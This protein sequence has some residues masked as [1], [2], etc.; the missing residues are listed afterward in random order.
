MFAVLFAS[1]ALAFL[2]SSNAQSSTA[3]S[4]LNAQE[5]IVV[6]KKVPI[7]KKRVCKREVAT[8]SIVTKMV[9]RS[10]E[11]EEAISA[12]SAATLEQIKR[13]QEGLKNM[14]RVMK[15][16]GGGG[17]LQARCAL[18][19]AS[20][21]GVCSPKGGWAMAELAAQD[22]LKTLRNDQRTRCGTWC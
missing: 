6:T 10:Q 19:T 14:R 8:G 4:P 2:V 7:K 18:G 22:T 20:S 17:Y 3:T 11:E 15:E 12:Q 5:E 1:S 9:C 21:K 16:G 13:D